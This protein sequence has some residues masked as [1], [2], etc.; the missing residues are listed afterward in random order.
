MTSGREFHAAALTL[1]AQ[2]SVGLKCV[3]VL[4]VTTDSRVVD[5]RTLFGNL[6]SA[7]FLTIQA[8]MPANADSRVYLALGAND[9]G[10]ISETATG[11]G[12]TVCFPL[13]DKHVIQGTILSGDMRSSG[14]ATSILSSY[15]YYKGLAT[16][17]I[18]IARSSVQ[19]GQGAGAFPPP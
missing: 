12:A 16:G 7:S 10:S 2:N 5:L 13:P 8:D 4:S 3:A 9:A 17:Y 11:N 18:R 1:P 15:L 14:V 19:P 6:H